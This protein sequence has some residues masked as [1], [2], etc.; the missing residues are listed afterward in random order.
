M[1]DTATKPRP[2]L[3]I[4]ANSAWNI[5][6]FR[7]GLI[8]GL[9][10]AGFD[11]VA[12]APADGHEDRLGEAGIGFIPLPMSRS[13]MNPV[14]DLQL[15]G[16]YSAIMR[17]LRPAAYL[18]FTIKPNIYGAIAARAHGIRAIN[19]VS[20]LGT[21]FLSRGW[22]SSLAH[23]LYRLAFARSHTVFF[24][25]PE[26]RQHFIAT[27]TVRPAQARLLPGS[28]IDPSRFTP[29]PV[30]AGPPAFLFIG[31]LLADKGVREFGAAAEIVRKALPDAQFR[32]LGGSDPG[33][34]SSIPAAE[35]EQWRAGGIVELLG[36][37]ND[38]RPHIEAASAVVLPSY[39]EGLPRVLL[40]GGAMGRP[41]LA[42]D[43]PGC[44]TIVAAG[45]N[46]LL[47]AARDVSALTRAMLEFAGLPDARRQ[48]MGRAARAVVEQEYDEQ[49]VIDAYLESLMDIAPASGVR[50]A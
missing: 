8:A 3:L 15:I 30:P 13:G 11:V 28:G 9:E 19:N 32:V 38:V 40:E 42:S 4:S 7:M 47:F 50:A 10:R 27:G 37:V 39:R 43:V 26:D 45:E 44:R 35:I 25:N 1:T 23:A 20:G 22:Q 24:Q 41:L 5:A 16:R 2:R 17:E 21:M 18:G 31:R 46:G 36:E 6:N 49:R 33:N 29:T 34:R 14:A 48:E 12:A